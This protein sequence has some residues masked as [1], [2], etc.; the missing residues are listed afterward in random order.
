MVPVKIVGDGN[1]APACEEKELQGFRQVSKICDHLP[2]YSL[3]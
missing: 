1:V 2:V 3:Q